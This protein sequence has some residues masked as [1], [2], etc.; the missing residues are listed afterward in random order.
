MDPTAL[1]LPLGYNSTWSWCLFIYFN[2][3]G[4][5]YFIFGVRGRKGHVI[6]HL[7]RERFLFRA[8]DILTENGNGKLRRQYNLILKKLPM[9]TYGCDN[10]ILM[11]KL[12]RWNNVIIEW[13]FVRIYRTAS[14]E[15]NQSSFSRVFA[16]ILLTGDKV[17]PSRSHPVKR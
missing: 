13:H 2:S 1:C 7:W 9:R 14:S 17:L 15:R 16:G 8:G 4:Y 3:Q 12:F 11:N 10:I 6:M 5:F